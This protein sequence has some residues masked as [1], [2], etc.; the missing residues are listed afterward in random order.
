LADLKVIKRIKGI[1]E[2]GQYH[3]L[4]DNPDSAQNSS[5]LVPFPLILGQ[6]TSR[7]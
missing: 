7:F 5:V 4:G 6:V 2:D 3:L 1:H